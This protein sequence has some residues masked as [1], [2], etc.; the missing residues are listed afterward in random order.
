MAPPKSVTKEEA[1]AFLR[2]IRKDMQVGE[3]N[4]KFNRI[5]KGYSFALDL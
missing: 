4:D 1:D 5:S 3:M 2:N